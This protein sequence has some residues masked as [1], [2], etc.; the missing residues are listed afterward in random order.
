MAVF[1]IDGY[2]AAGQELGEFPGTIVAIVDETVGADAIVAFEDDVPSLT[3]LDDRSA[4]V[5]LTPASPSEFLARVEDGQ[6]GE[7]TIREGELTGH[8]K[9]S[10]TAETGL[11]EKAD[12]YRI[13]FQVDE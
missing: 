8:Y 1:T 13:F 3:S 10:K 4:R 5:V 12:F 11:P 2:L 6:I 9:G 7:V